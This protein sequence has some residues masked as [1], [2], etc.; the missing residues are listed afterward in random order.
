MKS[1]KLSAILLPQEF[2]KFMASNT[3]LETRKKFCVNKKHFFKGSIASCFFFSTD[4][5]S[6]SS[7][8]QAYGVHGIKL[9]YTIEMRG[10]GA[11]GDYGFFLPPQFII[12][13]AE[14]ILQGLVSLVQRAQDI[15]YLRQAN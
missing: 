13:N 7:P 12:P 11:Y 9:A 8:D 2:F 5:S 10:E 14:E 4:A 1:Y 15:G 3:K 6:G